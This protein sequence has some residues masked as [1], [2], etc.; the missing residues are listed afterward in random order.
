MDKNSSLAIIEKMR[1]ASLDHMTHIDNLGSIFKSG[2]LAHNNPFK[3]IDISN[4]EVNDR[5]N[6]KDPIYNK[7]IHDYVPLYFNPRNAMLYR[8]QIKFGD[9]IV[10]L[11]FKKDTILLENSF[12]TNGNVASNHTLYSN[13]IRELEHEAWDWNRI[14]SRSWNEQPDAEDIKWSMMAEVLIYEK[15]ETSQLQA[16]Y[17]SSNNAKQHIEKHYHPSNIE[18]SVN[19]QVFF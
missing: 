11:A 12:F 3:K 5:R 18:I 2:L 10:I 19:T 1:I 4:R 16:I 6:K 14:W 9:A 13:D 15:L 17:C 8:N 7:N